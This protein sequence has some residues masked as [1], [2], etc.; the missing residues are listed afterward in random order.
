[1]IHALQAKVQCLEYDLGKELDKMEDLHRLAD[2]V[3][4]LEGALRTENLVES[5]GKYKE[6]V[7]NMHTVATD[8]IWV[9]EAVVEMG[10]ADQLELQRRLEDTQTR[11]GMELEELRLAVEEYLREKDDYTEWRDTGVHRMELAQEL[12]RAEDD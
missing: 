2:E 1:M 8:R 4:H 6:M 5:K 3:Q 12:T 10:E 9:L 7:R 11:V